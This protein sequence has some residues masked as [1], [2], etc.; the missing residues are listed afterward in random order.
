MKPSP[1]L[2]LHRPGTWKNEKLPGLSVDMG[3]RI[4]GHDMIE[5]YGKLI[6][7]VVD[8]VETRLCT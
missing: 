8:N 2:E 5:S 4:E 3:E 6:S 1:K 7:P